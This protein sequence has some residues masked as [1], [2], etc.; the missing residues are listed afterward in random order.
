MRRI[1]AAMA[2]RGKPPRRALAQ[3][4]TT[5]ATTISVAF[6]TWTIGP[7]ISPASNRG[8]AENVATRS[9]ATFAKTKKP[10]PPPAT[11]AKPTAG[12]ASRRERR[13]IAMNAECGV[14]R[15]GSESG[16]C[17]QGSAPRDSAAHDFRPR[18]PPVSRR[19]PRE[20]RLRGASGARVLAAGR[21]LRGAAE[22]AHRRGALRVLRR[23]A[24]GER[25]PRRPPR[26]LARHQ[27]RDLPLSLDARRARRAEGRMG[28]PRAPRGAGGR[29]EARNLG[30]EAD[31]GARRREIQRSLP[32]ER[33]QVL[34]GVARALRA[35]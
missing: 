35:D 8:C 34:G 30:Q 13:E 6:T 11:R 5:R 31:R 15:A 3:A 23:A 33:L 24:D 16:I 14:R 26:L 21:R 32:R 12:R 17:A 29:E 4:R 28:H 27:G 10:I 7:T 22:T 9:K 19:L 20:P 1:A 2:R 18:V 25:S